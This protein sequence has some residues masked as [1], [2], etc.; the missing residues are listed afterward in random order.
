MPCP[1]RR[2]KAELMLTPYVS[3]PVALRGAFSG[4]PSGV[5]ALSAVVND[6]PHVLVASSFTVG[7][8][9]EPPLV[10]FA[11]QKTS[12]TWPILAGAD[13]VGVS[14]LGERHVDKTRQ[15]ASKVKGSRFDGLDTTI[16]ESGAV[17][18]HGS[19]IW[20]E[21]SVEQTYPAGDHDIVVLRILSLLS[22]FAHSPLV[23]HRSAFTTLSA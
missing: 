12:T 4:F 11:V 20:L 3:D 17:F 10:M 6:E 1:Q 15:L 16:A 21:C 22:D 8:S 2:R 7:V 23:W 5:V 14:I 19:P 9:Q 13:A 18:L